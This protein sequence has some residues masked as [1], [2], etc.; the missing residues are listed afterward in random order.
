MKSTMKLVTM[1]CAMTSAVMLSSCTSPSGADAVQS[2]DFD[3]IKPDPAVAALV[4]PENRDSLR[5][6]MELHYS[7]A[8][9]LDEANQPA[10]YEVDVVKALARVMG[11]TNLEIID[12]DFDAIIPRVNDGTYDVGMASITINKHRLYQANLI[13]YIQA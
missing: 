7:P 6:A 11:V 1:A 9:Y 5:V 3:S 2:Y 13:A 10:G 8:E 12:E 4:P